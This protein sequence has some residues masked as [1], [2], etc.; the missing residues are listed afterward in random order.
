MSESDC[1]N[2]CFSQ[3]SAGYI[4]FISLLTHSLTSV[5][6]ALFADP[7]TDERRR[8]NLEQTQTIIG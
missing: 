1:F 4:L 3:N 2:E 8:M 7:L 6:H 5:L